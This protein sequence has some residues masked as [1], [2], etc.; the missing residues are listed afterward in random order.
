MPFP[1]GLEGKAPAYK[2]GD[3]GSVLGSEEPLE[4]EIATLSSICTWRIPWTEEPDWPQSTGSQRVGHNWATSLH[5]I[6]LLIV[7]IL[8]SGIGQLLLHNQL[9]Q[10]SMI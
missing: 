8:G 7:I 3:P 10:S 9:S 4:K 2:A 1:G 5:F 6:F